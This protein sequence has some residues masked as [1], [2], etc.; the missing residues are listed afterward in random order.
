GY[1]LYGSS[2]VF[3][4]TA[5]A[6]VSMFVLDPSIGAFLKVADDLRI[7]KSGKTYSLNEGNRPTFPAGYQRYLDWAQQNGSSKRQR[8]RTGLGGAQT[9]A[10]GGRVPDPADEE[11][12]RR[13]AAPHVRGEPD[14]DDRRAGRRSG[15]RWQDAHPRRRTADAPPAHERRPGQPRRSAARA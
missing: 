8:R 4:F 12:A 6:G 11:G 10:R 2:T 7:P 14:G 3:V 5:G 15:I 1:I 13:Q 9:A